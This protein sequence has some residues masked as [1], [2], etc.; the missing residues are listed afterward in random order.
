[1]NR[2]VQIQER[3]KEISGEMAAMLEGDEGLTEEQEALYA[4]METEAD[5]LTAE[6]AELRAEADK[7]ERR[8]K[9]DEIRQFAKASTRQTT[10]N[11]TTPRIGRV[12]AG[13]EDDPKKGF[14]SF[15][16][17]AARVFDAGSSPRNDEM[18][19]QVAAGT[20]MSQSISIDGGVLVPPAFSRTI[21][22]KVMVK[23]N[24]MLSYCNVI[25]VDAGVESVTVPAL[26]E[27][28][29]ADGS[30]QG[31]IQGYWKSELGA[32]TSSQPK[33]RETKFTPQELYVFAYIADKLLRNAPQLASTI[34]ENG[35]ADEIAFKIGDAI[36][37]GDGVG[38]P[39]GIVGHTATVSVS[40]ETGQA[41]ATIVTENVNKMLDRLHVNADMGAVWFVNPEV[42]SA[43]RNLTFPVGVGGLP[44]MLPPGGLSDS[45]Y[46]T[47]YGKPIIP[48]EYCAAL[49]TAGD[50][51]LA[52]LQWY[53][54]AIKG[55]V[56]SAYSM[57]LK[58][59]YAQ[60]AYRIIFE[61]DG[62]PWLADKITPYKGSATTSP[63]V[64]LATRA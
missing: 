8:Q 12:K 29:R 51:I 22:D 39:R 18:L 50:I 55:M 33:F 43:L 25:P 23:S 32:M 56:D 58:F 3:L 28:S 45:P 54:A 16:H 48:I 5:E 60:T 26:N 37:N 42:R 46:G 47:L 41:A 38:K 36:I 17:F 2:Q 57:H 9:A 34:L 64:T 40:K 44:V 4:Q 13:V 53:A 6:L 30:R 52:N 19:M 63:I 7:Q 21:W 27:T 49:G 31:G 24:S 11:R 14:K 61:M 1:M 20:G 59:D 62:Q 35:A 10:P 15:A